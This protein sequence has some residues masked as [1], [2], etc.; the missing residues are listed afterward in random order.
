MWGRC[1]LH[2]RIQGDCKPPIPQGLLGDQAGRALITP[3]AQRLT[4]ITVDGTLRAPSSEGLPLRRAGRIL[5]HAGHGRDEMDQQGTVR[6]RATHRE[7]GRVERWIS[8]PWAYLA[9]STTHPDGPRVRIGRCQWSF[10]SPSARSGLG[11][12]GHRIR[13]TPCES[14]RLSAQA[15]WPSSHRW[16]QYAF[17][18]PRYPQTGGPSRHPR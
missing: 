16:S 9:A 10:P 4:R 13:R 7:A 14:A 3:A 11:L 18:W 12:S 5:A 2:R 1:S 6:V 17:G 8:N 15:T